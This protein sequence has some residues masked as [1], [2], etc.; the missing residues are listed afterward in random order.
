MAMPRQP[1]SIEIAEKVGNELKLEFYEL[2]IPPPFDGFA[3]FGG[4][5]PNRFD[6]GGDSD[7]CKGTRGN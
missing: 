2:D 1:Q 4:K 3:R 5:A 7:E 6:I